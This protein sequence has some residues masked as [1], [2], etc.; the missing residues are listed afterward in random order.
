VEEEVE[1]MKDLRERNS[2]GAELVMM[3]I[4]VCSCLLFIVAGDGGFVDWFIAHRSTFN[5]GIFILFRFRVVCITPTLAVATATIFIFT[6]VLFG[7]LIRVL[8]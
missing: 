6:Y 3:N 8:L 2:V 4:V 7:V 5:R 1:G